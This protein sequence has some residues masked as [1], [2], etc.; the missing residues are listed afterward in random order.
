MGGGAG[1]KKRQPPFSLRKKAGDT[2][3]VGGTPPSPRVPNTGRGVLA[4]LSDAFSEQNLA[5]APVFFPRLPRH[6][7]A[8]GSTTVGRGLNIQDEC[9]YIIYIFIFI[10]S[11]F[12]AA[13]SPAESTLLGAKAALQAA[14]SPSQAGHPPQR[15]DPQSSGPAPADCHSS[16]QEE[17][18][19]SSPPKA[20]F[21]VKPSLLT[22]KRR[23]VKALGT[24]TKS[25]T[26]EPR[27]GWCP[28]LST[29]HKAKLSTRRGLR[30]AEGGFCQEASPAQ[31]DQASEAA[32]HP[33]VVD[34]DHLPASCL[35]PLQALAFLLL[36]HNHRGAVG[37]KE[38]RKQG[39][40]RTGHRPLGAQQPRPAQGPAWQSSL[41]QH[42]AP[43]PHCRQPG[44]TGTGV[45]RATS[46][47]IPRQSEASFPFPRCRHTVVH[48]L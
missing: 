4:P 8:G 9:V 6:R 27:W 18:P 30:G 2:P 32:Q 1:E 14:P 23:E 35:L 42:F 24:A 19:G 31:R 41:A 26:G 38:E 11:F 25:N 33:S 13:F 34:A 22:P 37:C 20:P 46:A 16:G 10:E 7:P 39:E 17:K 36:L 48:P 21:G 43:S 28:T 29:P 45:T 47:P 40:P 44:G 5:R 3:G 15:H 12:L